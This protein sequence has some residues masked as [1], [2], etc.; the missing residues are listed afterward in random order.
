METAKRDEILARILELKKKQDPTMLE[1]LKVIRFYYNTEKLEKER[2]Y[3]EVP[4]PKK[5]VDSILED[6]DKE[7]QK[8]R[9]KRYYVSLK[10]PLE[11]GY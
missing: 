8:P 1:K 2:I 7:R 4:W 5:D 11:E 3:K 6:L 10:E 9:P